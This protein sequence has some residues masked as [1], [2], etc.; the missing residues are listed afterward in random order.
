MNYAAYVNNLIEMAIA[1][2]PKIVS[3]IIILFIG[4]IVG[5]ILGKYISKVLDKIGLDDLLLKTAF[6]QTIEKSS[7]T[8]VKFFD[9]VIRAFVYLIAI[10]AAADVLDI[11][12]LSEYLQMIV[13]YI[14]SVLAFAAI[15][16]VGFIL[17]D[18]FADFLQD[19]GH[20]GDVQFMKPM[21]SVMRIFLYLMVLILAL[22][23]LRV[24][25]TIIYILIEP[26]AWGIGLGVGAAIAIIVGF[27]LKDKSPEILNNFMSKVKK[28]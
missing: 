12:F 2:L 13:A 20:V 8:V 10:M 3:A 5:R 23:Q 1:F 24:D 22:T 11:E 26:L 17:I 14:P 28:E 19:M 27:G 21:I 7:I 6:G 9:Y 4:W 18:F 16:I 25:L 15:L